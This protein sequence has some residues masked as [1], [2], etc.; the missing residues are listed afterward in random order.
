VAA[1]ARLAGDPR[2]RRLRG[3]E[4]CVSEWGAGALRALLAGPHWGGL[5]YLCI[6]NDDCHG[7]AAE[8][9]AACPSL[10]RLVT[11]DFAGDFYGDLADAGVATLALAHG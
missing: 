1:A 10:Y 7:Y 6:G 2:V 3:L 5:E 9:I 4:L 8:A 11:L